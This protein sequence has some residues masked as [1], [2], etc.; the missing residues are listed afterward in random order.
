MYFQRDPVL[1]QSVSISLLGNNNGRISNIPT[2]KDLRQG[3]RRLFHLN[4][5][6]LM[7][8]ICLGGLFAN[9]KGGNRYSA[10]ELDRVR[11][12]IFAEILLRRNEARHR[13]TYLTYPYGK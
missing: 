4:H 11:M 9:Y 6:L 12:M 7:G 2:R 8:L 5:R 3:N 10:I 1:V 13:L